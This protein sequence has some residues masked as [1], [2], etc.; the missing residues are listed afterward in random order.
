MKK[1]YN[2]LLIGFGLIIIAII[3][4]ISL[5]APTPSIP[6]TNNTKWFDCDVLPDI[7]IINL[8]IILTPIIA[9]IGVIILFYPTKESEN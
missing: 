6:I 4:P 9:I 5:Y 7:F 8:L 1:I 2:I 3:Y